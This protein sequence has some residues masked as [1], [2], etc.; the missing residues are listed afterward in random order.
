MSGFVPVALMRRLD[1]GRQRLRP[2]PS[3]ERS[4]AQDKATITPKVTE[5]RMHFWLKALKYVCISV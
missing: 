5:L 3:A 2:N 1:E 4:E